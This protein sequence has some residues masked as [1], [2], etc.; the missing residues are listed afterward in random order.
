MSSI[1]LSTKYEYFYQLFW[2]IC[3]HIFFL[4]SVAWARFRPLPAAALEYVEMMT[5]V[6]HELIIVKDKYLIL[7]R[8]TKYPWLV[9]VVVPSCKPFLL[10]LM[11]A[12][13]VFPLY[14]V[15]HLIKHKNQLSFTT[16][17]KRR[18]VS[19]KENDHLKSSQGGSFFCW[20]A[21]SKQKR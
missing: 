4:V 10:L 7:K 11:K 20:K 17:L 14:S 9:E 13:R 15:L 8:G 3:R 19:S 2:F 21:L 1:P 18:D 5:W 16:L 12:I 6:R